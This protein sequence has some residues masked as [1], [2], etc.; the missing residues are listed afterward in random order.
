VGKT[1]TRW[2]DVVQG[3][4]SQILGIRE[5]SRQA[6][7]KEEWR[8]LLREAR[9]QKGLYRHAWN[10]A[11]HMAL[12]NT[13]WCILYKYITYIN[14]QHLHIYSTENYTIEMPKNVSVPLK[15]SHRELILGK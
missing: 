1:R 11:E 7:D 3:D 2:E 4:T 10:G 13:R 15:S 9:A 6:E 8:R 14:H 12:R 5:W